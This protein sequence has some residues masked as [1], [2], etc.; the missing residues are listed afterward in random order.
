MWWESAAR[1]R[2]ST[3]PAAP[4][5]RLAVIEDALTPGEG[6]EDAKPPELFQLFF[7]ETG[8]HESDMP[9]KGAVHTLEVFPLGILHEHLARRLEPWKATI[10]QPAAERL[11]FIGSPIG[12]ASYGDIDP[13]SEWCGLQARHR[14]SS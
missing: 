14:T 4:S 3:R 12:L 9:P 8:E 11:E 10:D 2:R 7:G 1:T 13:L 5:W 6:L